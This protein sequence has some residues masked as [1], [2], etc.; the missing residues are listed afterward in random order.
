[1]IPGFITI[2]H[3]LIAVD[4]YLV[5][6]YLYVENLIL[7]LWMYVKGT[8]PL[9]IFTGWQIATCCWYFVF[10]ELYW[11]ATRVKLLI[12]KSW[13]PFSPCAQISRCLFNCLLICYKWTLWFVCLMY[14]VSN[15]ICIDF[16]SPIQLQRLAF[17]YL[18]F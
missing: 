11:L 9:T 12:W 14:D 5:D 4:R 15:K 8:L 6:R 3:K 17:W 16:F 18:K 7:P 1:M 2:L 10:K 13:S